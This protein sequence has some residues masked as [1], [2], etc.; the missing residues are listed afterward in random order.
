MERSLNST[1]DLILHL[2]LYPG[3]AENYTEE[4]WRPG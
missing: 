3:E 4:L 1:A 2:R